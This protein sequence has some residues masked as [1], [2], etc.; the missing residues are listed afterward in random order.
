LAVL[1]KG[2]EQRYELQQQNDQLAFDN[3]QLRFNERY[4]LHE[5]RRTYT[6][7]LFRMVVG[8]LVFVGIIV[9]SSAA[10]WSK[11]TDAVLIALITTTTANVIGMFLIA[12]RWLFPT[13]PKK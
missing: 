13:K 8:W 5:L 4:D 12:A 11:I 9:T 6:P 10:G 1:G 2:E 7:H 3:K